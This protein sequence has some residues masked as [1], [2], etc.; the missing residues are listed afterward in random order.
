[1][2][3]TNQEGAEQLL[4]SYMNR[5][6]RG[7]FICRIGGKIKLL[8]ANNKFLNLYECDTW[9]EIESATGK[10]AR[11]LI[12]YLDQRKILEALVEQLGSGSYQFHNISC[13]I[14]TAK[15]HIRQVEVQVFFVNSEDGPLLYGCVEDYHDNLFAE[16]PDLFTKLPDIHQLWSHARR[17]L[18]EQAEGSKT[19]NWFYV[20]FDIHPFKQRGSK[21]TEKEHLDFLKWYADCVEKYFGNDCM[22]HAGAD[23][24]VVFTGETGLFHKIRLIHAL[25]ASWQNAKTGEVKAGIYRIRQWEENP[26]ESCENARLACDSLRG[27]DEQYFCQYTPSLRKNTKIQE[28][29]STTL[30]DA[31]KKGYLNI[32]YQPIVRPLNNTLCGMEALV[33]WHDPKHGLLSPKLFIDMLEE[34]RQIHKMDIFVIRELCRH[35]RELADKGLDVLPVSFNLSKLDFLYCDIFQEIEKAVTMYQVPR[36]MLHIEITESA[37]AYDPSYMQHELERFRQQGYQ[38]WMDD[39]GSGYS[40][41]NLLKQYPFSGVKLDMDFM[42]NLNDRG[43]QII[44]SF[45]DMCKK[46]GIQTLVEGVETKEQYDFLKKI[47]CEMVQGYYFG[48]PLPY[49]KFIVYCQDHHI[50]REPLEQR[51]YYE[52]LSQVNSISE[53]SI[54]LYEYDGKSFTPLFIHPE[55]AFVMSKCAIHST[56][57][58]TEDIKSPED[59]RYFS[60]RKLASSTPTPGTTASVKYFLGQRYLHT[61]MRNIAVFQNR[62]ALLVSIS[63]ITDETGD[64]LSVDR[65]LR[66]LRKLYDGVF[67]LNLKDN[68]AER[69]LSRNTTALIETA[70]LEGSSRIQDLDWL[71]TYYAEMDV[72][73]QDRER[74]MLY[75]DPRTLLARIEECESGVLMDHFRTKNKDGEYEWSEHSV[76]LPDN[77]K[78]IVVSCVKQLPLTKEKMKKLFTWIENKT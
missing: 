14:Q 53:P 45:I 47:N 72:H 21:L 13:R 27:L 50:R 64:D 9:E 74:Y 76:F 63:D 62:T 38:I 51:A 67:L 36:H 2:T 65:A 60:Y 19:P 52:A 44:T 18:K 68:Y 4:L 16:I 70:L 24:I 48:R 1:M 23:H 49:D 32:Y 17:I 42:F 66:S 61:V 3:L 22:A 58:L 20:Y 10:T 12:Y 15:K 29:I 69:L 33:R 25:V 71:R 46:M 77:T 75:S 39:F 11:N 78:N 6:D 56:A 57:A 28:H 34:T 37:M 35:Y 54:A 8:F 30:E 31:L 40:T 43:R 59:P 7:F 73:P 41:L 5:M 55:Y 26:I